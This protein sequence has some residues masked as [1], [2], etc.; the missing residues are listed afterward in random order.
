MTPTPL[1]SI[2][3]PGQAWDL[4]RETYDLRLSEIVRERTERLQEDVEKIS[5]AKGKGGNSRNYLDD[6]IEVE[7]KHTNDRAERIYQL[8]CE[9]WSHKKCAAFFQAL[10]QNCLL[11]LFRGREGAVIGQLKE[12]HRSLKSARSDAAI[13]SFGE[14]IACLRNEWKVRLDAESRGCEHIKPRSGEILGRDPRT[15]ESAVFVTETPRTAPEIIPRK[16]APR[17]KPK[18]LSVAARKKRK[19]IFGAIQCC[20]EG[21][22]YCHELESK[23]VPIRT[24]W[25]AEGCPPTYG[26]A[27]KAAPTWRKRIQDEKYRFKREYDATSADKREEIIQG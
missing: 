20:L 16:S 18:P 23:D 24:E 13:R 1:E 6:R 11:P 5:S 15:M 17:A 26:A 9:I 12:E 7:L 8:C 10:F 4:M 22:E 19:V 2:I 3:T 27:Y 14:D 25:I 21:P